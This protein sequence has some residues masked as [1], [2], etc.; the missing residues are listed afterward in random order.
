[1]RM[2]LKDCNDLDFS[3]AGMLGQLRDVGKT[4]FLYVGL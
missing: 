3:F 2:P 4:L 1:M